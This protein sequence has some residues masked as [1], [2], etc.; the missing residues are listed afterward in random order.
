M[1][2]TR[3]VLYFWPCEWW[4]GVLRQLPPD[5]AFFG[6]DQ[7]F[8]MQEQQ[9]ALAGD[10]EGVYYGLLLLFSRHGVYTLEFC[11]AQTSS[12]LP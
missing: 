11:P 5:L 2:F 10:K 3:T 4:R 7:P 8:S 9:V 12:S 1:C 6:L